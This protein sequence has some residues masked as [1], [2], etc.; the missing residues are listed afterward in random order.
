MVRNQ[1]RE[2]VA[3]AAGMA[4]WYTEPAII[5]RPAFYV[6]LSDGC[7]AGECNCWEVL[8][9]QCRT[10][11][12]PCG[13][14]CRDHHGWGAHTRIEGCGGGGFV[15]TERRAGVPGRLIDCPWC[16]EDHL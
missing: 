6:C 9:P 4:G 7:E 5:G 13:Q 11:A 1:T 8:P 2:D 16:P 12:V 3:R 15:M 10:F 14:E